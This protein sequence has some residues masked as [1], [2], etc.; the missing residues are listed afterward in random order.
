MTRDEQ[1]ELNFLTELLEQLTHFREG[2]GQQ[3]SPEQLDAL[4]ALGH[5]LIAIRRAEIIASRSQS[6]S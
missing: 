6:N 4:I 5:R 3:A 2:N 1:I